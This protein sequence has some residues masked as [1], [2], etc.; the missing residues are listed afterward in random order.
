MNNV[1]D[2]LKLKGWLM[3]RLPYE[4]VWV[5][6]DGQII[7]ANAK[8]CEGVGYSQKECMNLK[9][10]DINVTVTPE[11]WK[12]HWEEVMT[13]GAVQFRAVHKTKKGKFYEVEV[14]VQKFSYNGKNYICGTTNEFSESS[15][16]KNLIDNTHSIANV[17]GWEL[18][19]H[20]GSILATSC[21][22]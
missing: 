8:F 18:N 5:R 14:H 13:K 19:L 22:S 17:G 3:D 20:D 15:F 10:S 21:T 12:N 16:Y 11:S 6:E 9:V 1:T 2:E 4:M 7:Y